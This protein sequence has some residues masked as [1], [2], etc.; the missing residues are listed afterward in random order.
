MSDNQDSVGKRG[1]KMSTPWEEIEHFIKQ[2]PDHSATCR[3]LFEKM[4]NMLR[5]MAGVQVEFIARPGVTYSLRAARTNDTA[6]PLFAMVD[7]ID[8]EPRWLS[9]CFYADMISDPGERGDYV[10]GGLLGEDGLCFDIEDD[11]NS[12]ITYIVD[13]IDE[14]YLA[15]E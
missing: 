15:A 3:R 13:R 7:V 12:H 8:A 1:I 2:W 4:S 11:N 14:A 6:R 10:P 5:S 9:V